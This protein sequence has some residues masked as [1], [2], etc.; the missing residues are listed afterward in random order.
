MCVC[1][2]EEKLEHMLNHLQQLEITM[3]L[4]EAKVS[5]SRVCEKLEHMSNCLQQLEIT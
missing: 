4:L 5:S 3:N 1:V 2:Y